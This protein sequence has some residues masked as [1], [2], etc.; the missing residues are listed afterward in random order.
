M[1]FSLAHQRK[2]KQKLSTNLTLYE[3]HT[4]HWANFRRAEIKVK[5]DFNLLQGKNSTFLEAWEK[6][7]SNTVSL[8]KK[9]EKAEKY[10]TNKGTNYKHRSPNK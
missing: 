6:E 2:N 10:Y 8:K 9:K 7:T 5:K 3:A 1:E 4:N